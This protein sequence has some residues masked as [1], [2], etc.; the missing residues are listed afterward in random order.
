MRPHP[1]AAGIV[2][3]VAAVVMALAVA[4]V[5][6]LLREYGDVRSSGVVQGFTFGL[7][8][9]AVVGLIAAAGVALARQARWSILG[10]L[11]VVLLGVTGIGVAGRDGIAA[12]LADR[13]PSV[14]CDLGATG[15]ADP[16]AAEATRRATEAFATLRHPGS[17]GG[18][19][20]QSTEGC[21]A[22]VE[23]PAERLDAAL[24]DYRGQL[25]SLGWT[26]VDSV[27]AVTATRGADEISVSVNRSTATLRLAFR[28]R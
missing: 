22:E 15:A 17:I 14:L 8:P 23:V 21:A 1:R 25:A 20:E 26:V 24:G 28:T 11:A 7:A 9:L 12:K 4:L 5:A 18:V 2:L 13:A 27:D 6:A 10:A 3:A 16:A 19:I